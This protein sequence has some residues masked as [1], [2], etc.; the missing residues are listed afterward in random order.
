VNLHLRHSEYLLEQ[1]TFYRGSESVN[2]IFRS[3]QAI[4]KLPWPTLLGTWR[5]KTPKEDAHHQ[6]P[7]WIITTESTRLN[8]SLL[9]IFDQQSPLSF[10][11]FWY[12]N[13]A[14]DLKNCRHAGYVLIMKA[15]AFMA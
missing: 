5:M 13:P 14:D 8:S 6:C 2:E 10:S 1:A 11:A 4:R 3:L 15:A 7:A 12:D 9:P